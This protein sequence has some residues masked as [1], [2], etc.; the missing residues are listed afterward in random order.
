MAPT[1]GSDAPFQFANFQFA[2]LFSPMCSPD[3]MAFHLW[4]LTVHRYARMFHQTKVLVDTLVSAVRDA[5][6]QPLNQREP[7]IQP[8][9]I[10]WHL[11]PVLSVWIS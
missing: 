3:H 1:A 7:R 4:M 2:M 11:Q 5:K 9:T 8:A 10:R 6:R